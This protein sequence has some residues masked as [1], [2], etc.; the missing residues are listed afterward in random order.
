[1]KLAKMDRTPARNV[2]DL[3]RK[4]MF[5]KRFD[6][7]KQAEEEARQKVEREMLDA[8]WKYVEETKDQIPTLIAST[9]SPY[10]FTRNQAGTILTI[11]FFINCP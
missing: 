9:A 1:M 4:Y 2:R 7:V 8:Y 5:G 10:K 11:R 3:E 6:D